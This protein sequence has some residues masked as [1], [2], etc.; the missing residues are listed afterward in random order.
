[1][2]KLT[3]KLNKSDLN[4]IEFVMAQIAKSIDEGF[5]SGV[6]FPVNWQLKAKGETKMQFMK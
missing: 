5:T 3:I 4:N 1:M 6:E 2:K